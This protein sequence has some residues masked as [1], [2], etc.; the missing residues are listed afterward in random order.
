LLA[1][2]AVAQWNPPNAVEGVEKQPDGVLLRMQ[3]G[4]LRL[5]VGSEMDSLPFAGGLGHVLL[6]GTT[7]SP[8]PT[9]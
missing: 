1:S 3:T 6:L 9:G 2:N 7:I 8:C 4:L 5:Q